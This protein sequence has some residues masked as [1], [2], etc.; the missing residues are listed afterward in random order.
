MP[1]KSAAPRLDNL[2][3]HAKGHQET[4]EVHYLTALCLSK[5]GPS[6]EALREIDATLALDPG[7][8]DARVLRGRIRLSAGDQPGAIDDLRSARALRP[9]SVT[10]R[11]LFAKTLADAGRT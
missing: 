10:L 3:Q 5:V 2:R 4:A 6:A 1:R 9:E 8:I 7:H 11:G